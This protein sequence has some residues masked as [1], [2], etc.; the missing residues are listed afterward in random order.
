VKKMNKETLKKMLEDIQTGDL[1]VNNAMERLETL[2]FEDLGYANVDY[3]RGIRSHSNEVIFC[4]GKSTEHI[5][6]ISQNMISKNLENIMLT[7]ASEDIYN[8]LCSITQ[9]LTY[10]KDA[11]IIIINP[12]ENIKTDKIIMVMSAGT[13]DIPI[14]E[15]AAVVAQVLG[16]PVTRAYDVGVAGI[17][18]LFARLDDIKKANVI[19]VAAGMEGALASVVG[20]LT[21]KPVI[22][23][24]TS[25]GYGSSMGGIAALLTMLNSCANGIGVVNIDNGFGAGYLASTI[26]QL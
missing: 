18:R 22:A 5:L 25:I 23:L 12:V 10:Y 6:G 1:S 2:P 3:H 24:P 17:H 11:R 13:A 20:G 21:D 16:N 14:A 9:K 8:A 19:I 7:R 15:E 26:N 4:Q